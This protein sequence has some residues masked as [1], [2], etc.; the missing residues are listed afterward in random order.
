ML[1][2]NTP[3]FAFLQFR[4]FLVV[5]S[6]DGFLVFSWLHQ[7][8]HYSIAEPSLQTPCMFVWPSQFV[9]HHWE[10]V[11]DA[12]GDILPLM[13]LLLTHFFWLFMT[14]FSSVEGAKWESIFFKAPCLGWNLCWKHIICLCHPRLASEK[15]GLC[16]KTIWENITLVHQTIYP[17]INHE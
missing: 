5:V 1:T 11:L 17:N 9:L 4:F 14:T 3:L 13:F 12:W 7:W 6:A 8:S 10:V 16:K 2:G 15:I